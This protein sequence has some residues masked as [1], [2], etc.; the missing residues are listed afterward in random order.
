MSIQLIVGLSNPGKQ[1]EKTRHNA[2]A[3]FV[4]LLAKE[5]HITLKPQSKYHGLYQLATLG[6]TPCHLLIP[7]T[8]MNESGKAV[9]ACAR[10]LRIPSH[11]IL[12]AH[13]DMDLPPG[14]ARLK[15]DGGDAGHNGLKNIIAHLHT[16][17][18]YR[19]RIGVGKPN[20]KDKIDY[21]LSHPNRADKKLIDDAIL[22]TY[23]ILPLVLQGE[24]QKAMHQ[25][26][27]VS[28]E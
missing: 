23:Q 18:F 22:K 13:D 27:T 11:H 1:Y 9:G 12:I 20:Q 7:T 17:Q 15:Q 26:H 16:K 8:Y 24:M 19:L 3:W 2:G 25:L 5:N 6:T 10:Y 4:E 28:S 21:V 14:T